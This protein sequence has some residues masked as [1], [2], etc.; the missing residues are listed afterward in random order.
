MSDQSSISAPSISLPKGGGAIRGI[1]EKFGANAATGTG[2]LSVPLA[3]SPGRSG[4]GPQLSLSYDSGA[5]NGP[6]GLGWSLALPSITRKTDKGLPRYN[7]AEDS[8]V[9]IISGA[10]DLVP[11]LVE[12]GGQWRPQSTVRTVDA[13]EYRIQGFRP[14]IE[15]LFARIERWTNLQTGVS[16]WRSISRDNIT[17]LYGEDN[18]SRVFDPADPDPE[19]PRR[20]FRWLICESHDDKGNVVIYDYKEENTDDVDLS[21]VHERNRSAQSR[22]ADRYLK[23]IRYGNRVSR[24]V[25][26]DTASNDWM[27][28]VVFDYGEHDADAPTPNDA[29]TWL[30]RHDPFSSY[31]AAFEIRSYR[32]CQRVLMFHHFSEEAAV[33]ENCLV[34]STNFIYQNNRN[35]PAD[36]RQ[37][38]PIASFLASITQSGYRRLPTGGYLQRSLP[39]IE[40][41]YS[42]AVVQEDLREI[43]LESLENLPYGI[44]GSRYQWL[45]LDGEGASGIVTEQGDGWFYKRNISPIS[46]RQNNGNEAMVALFSPVELIAKQPSLN[47][48]GAGSQQFLDLAGDGQIDLVQFGRPISGYFER[49]PNGDW[50][51]FVPFESVPSIAVGDPN[52]RF[53]D[54]TGDGHADILISEDN[55]FIW[56]PSLAEAGFGAGMRVAQALDEEQGPRLLFADGSQSIY[57]ADLSGDGL[58]DLVRIRNGGVCYWPNLGYGHFG[59]KVTMDGSPWFEEPDLFDQKRLLLADIDGSGVTDIIYLGRDR[60]NLYFNQS[61]NSWSEPQVLTQFPG[62]DN[63]SSV[64]TVDLLGNGT[65]CLVWS[66]PL[67]S[68]GARSMRYVDLMGGQKPHLL[69]RMTNNLGAETSVRYAPSTSFY[70]EDK[71][72]GTPWLTKLPFPVHVVERIETLDHVSRNRFVTRYAYHHGYFDGIEREFRG[73]G[74]VE[75]LD[76]EELAALSANGNLPPATNIEAASHVPP[77]LTRTWFHTG[78]LTDGGR[79]SR[80]FEQD[81]YREG[82]VSLGEQDLNEAQLRSMLLDDT[83]LPNT[84]RL[85][86]GNRLTWSISAEEAL[87]ACRALKGSILRQE[88]YALDGTEETDRPY[89]VTE[90]NYTIELLQPREDNRHAVFFAHPR[91]SVDFHYERRLFDIGGRMLADPRVTHSMTLAVDAFGNVIESVAIGYGRRHADPNPLLTDED[92]QKQERTQITWMTNRFTN[93]VQDDDSYRAPL[94]SE[95]RTFELLNI[96]HTANQPDVTN[97]FRFEEMLSATHVVADGLHDIPYENVFG[98]G[99]EDGVP[100]RRLIEHV[101]SLSRRDDLS[102]P[103]LLGQVE[104]RALPFESYKLA[105]TPGLVQQVYGDRVTDEMLANE[106][107]YVH[108]EDDGNWWIPSGRVFFSPNPDDSPEQ[109]LSAALDHFFLPH[110]FVDPFGSSTTVS[111]D[112]HD[113]LL[114][115]TRDALGNAV[116]SEND[117]RVMQPRL[118]TDPNGNR[119]SAAFDALGMVVGTAVMGKESETLGDSLAGFEPDLDEATITAHLQDPFTSPHDILNRAGA[120]MVYDVSRFQRTSANNNPQ[121]NVVY[122]LARETH[123]SD[124]QAGETSRIQ[125][126]FSYSDGFGRE[127]QKKVQAEP[128]SLV[129]GGPEVSPRWVGSGWA[130]FNNKGKPVRQYEPFFSATHQ[131]EFARTVGVSPI[132]FYDPVERVV[133]TLHPNHTWGKVV[134]DPWRQETWDVND[135]VLQADPRNDLDVADFFRRLPDS[136]Y[137]DTWHTQRAGGAFGPQELDAANKAAVHANTPAVVWLDSLGRPFLTVANNRFVRQGATIQEQYATRVELDIE[138]NQREVIDALDRAVMDYDYNM[139]GTQIHSASMEAGERWM[140]NDG[141]GQPIR[142]WDSRG[143]NFRTEYDELHRPAR[144][145]VTGADANDPNREILFQRTIYGEGQGVEFNHRGHVFQV[146]DGAGVVTSDGYDF[147]GNLLRGSRR[148]LVNYRDAADWSASPTLESEVFPSSTAYDALNRVATLATPDNSRIHPAYNEANLLERVEVNLRGASAVTTFV[149]DIDYNA[150]GQRELIE[151]G[152][153]VRTTSEYDRETFRLT[154]LRTLR[155]AELLQDLSYTYDPVG[156]ITTIRDESQQAIYFN[157][158]VVEAH[159]EY[160]Y[161]A[162]DRLIEATGREHIGQVSQPQSS[163]NDE[164]RVNLPHPQDGQAMRRYTQ[165]Y[166]YDGVGN[167]LQLIHQSQNGDWTRDYAYNEASLIEPPLTNNRLSSTEVGGAVETYTHDAHGN[168]THMPHLS[169][170]RWDYQDQ[171]EATSRQVVNNGGTPETTYYVYDAAGQRVRKVTER[172]AAAGQ[173]ATRRNERIYLGGFEVYR[174]F[175]ADGIT[176]ALERETLHIMGDQQ[177]VALIETRTMGNDGSPAQFIRYQ[178]GNHLASAGLEL[179]EGGSIISYEEYYPYGSTSY[180]AGRSLVEISRKRYRYT[181]KERDGETGL[182]YH[183]ARYYATWLGRWTAADPTGLLAGINRFRYGSNNPL[184]RIDPAGTIDIPLKVPSLEDIQVAASETASAIVDKAQDVAN[185][186]VGA[187]GDYLDATVGAPL[188]YVG[189]GLAANVGDAI[190]GAE[191]TYVDVATKGLTQTA[192]ESGQAAIEGVTQDV[193]SVGEGALGTVKSVAQGELSAAAAEYL[194]AAT[195]VWSLATTFTPSPGGG[196]F[197]KLGKKGTKSLPSKSAGKKALPQATDKKAITGSASH[198]KGAAGEKRAEHRLKSEGQQILSQ[199]FINIRIRREGTTTGFHRLTLDRA[200]APPIPARINLNEVKNGQSANYSGPQGTGLTLLKS[201]RFEFVRFTGKGA[202]EAGLTGKDFTPAQFRELFRLRTMTFG[203][204]NPKLPQR[205]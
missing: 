110:R 178:L 116:R 52:V 18:N 197:A 118:V 51:Q 130:I 154:H 22:S 42:Q 20:V 187:Y 181:G 134:F 36:L 83:I 45:D 161:D 41:E 144:S 24:L 27:F 131:F 203:G 98:D 64:A 93:A 158:Q 150:K 147:K 7:D 80:H 54:L 101:R 168:M 122:T 172:Q 56:Y 3:L 173:T 195:G 139:L 23:R 113:L 97:L 13:V 2:S 103:L 61:G 105:F 155:G 92:R 198:R 70:M 140:L 59:A 167:I 159:A 102:G 188:R 65:A 77:V 10:E 4:F 6:F 176:I 46:S 152:N 28:E 39:P 162:I 16:H 5:G 129:E 201:G 142:A 177:R 76:T 121:P 151:Y 146:F 58:T 124:L 108:I 31:R 87:E 190:L 37:G 163:W 107:H 202:K 128:G 136:E 17:T 180:Q 49:T 171:L 19:H 126:S 117:Y 182:N 60:V 21:A 74:M 109:E 88:V 123:D 138:G 100:R 34:R 68:E 135:T 164:F 156:N 1:G 90:S 81:Y 149:S 29:G 157:N 148:L 55:V 196:V 132:L 53:V 9:F 204:A 47:D 99:A 26:P 33:G 69:I 186:P 191:Q 78:A 115:E 25:D 63:L 160:T 199:T 153:G 193:V 200:S 127:I 86:N 67:P 145:F 165:G 185:D 133:A 8:D 170:M 112:S 114:T 175:D 15:G 111:Y 119:A 75:Q 184:N 91:E 57:L 95:A 120:R 12:E 85:P 84:V 38:H 44:D 73:F 30:C 35:N 169:L 48:D 89:N 79:V 82:D 137:L 72:A 183:R 104:S 43:D 62:I 179:D 189:E 174:E 194:K 14:R 125:H 40:L 32:L 205:R 106:G 141:A 166:E 11:V 50:S 96:E 143:H 94:P 192:L 66:S 71:F